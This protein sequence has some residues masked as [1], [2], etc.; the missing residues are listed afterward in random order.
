MPDLIDRN[1]TPAPALARYGTLFLC[2]IWLLAGAV[3]HDPWKAEDAMHLGVAFGMGAE[4][5]RELLEA[6]VVPVLVV[7]TEYVNIAHTF[8]GDDEPRVVNG[9][10]DTPEG[11]Q[12]IASIGLVPMPG[13]P[14]QL[15]AL[16]RR[17]TAALARLVRAAGITPE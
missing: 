14:A 11:R 3:G 1:H 17:D 2:A 6:K 15:A 9:V 13:S 5:V 8:L 12:F 7:I 4:S 10:L 16:Q